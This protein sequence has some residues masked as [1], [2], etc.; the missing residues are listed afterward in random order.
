MT[1]FYAEITGWGKC[2]PPTTLSNHDLS[3]FIETSDEWIKTRTG[4]EQRRI[5]HVNTSDLATVAAQHAIACAGIDATEI[6]LIIIATC[7]PDSL[8]PNI[9]SK[10]QQNLGIKNAAAF[11]LNAAC[12][13][14]VYGLE[15]ATRLMQSSHYRHALVVG[16]ERLSFYI[17]WTKRDTAVLFG[18][19]AGAVVLSKTDKVVGLQDAQIGCD[20]EG[21]DILAVPKFGSS[22]DRFAADNGYWDFDFVGKEIFKRAVRGMGAAAQ[23][24]LA[25]S[26][27]STEQVDVV[28]PHQANIRIIQTLCDLSGIS[29]DKAFVNIQHYGNTSAATVPIALCEAVEQG[30]IKPNDNLLVAAFGAGLTWGA[31][32]IKWGERVTAI[33]RSQA[34]LPEC[35]S[36][37]LELLANAIE[38]CQQRPLSK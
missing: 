25:R 26:G 38:H 14:F 7:S 24:V 33:S 15:T 13:G 12:T 36:S 23:T 5:S 21:R 35:Q 29:Q 22:M 32:H 19:G 10:V 4:I 11:D 34:Q 31:G 16:A 20:A 1:K 27:L 28:I 8:I 18:D 6:D 37:A 2:L 30:K 3:T 17:D 9:A